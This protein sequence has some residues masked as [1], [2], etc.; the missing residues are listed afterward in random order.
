MKRQSSRSKWGNPELKW[1]EG[2]AE[3]DLNTTAKRVISYVK[4]DSDTAPEVKAKDDTVQTVP[5]TRKASVNLVTKEV[6]YTDWEK[7]K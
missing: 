3:S 5:F 7:S 2:L 6:T 1:P 4:K